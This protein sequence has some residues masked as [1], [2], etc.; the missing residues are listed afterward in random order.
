[1]TKAKNIFSTLTQFRNLDC[2]LS[3]GASSWRLFYSGLRMAALCGQPRPAPGGR[4]WTC[5]LH[6]PGPAAQTIRTNGSAI[7][8]I[9]SARASHYRQPWGKE[10]NGAVGTSWLW[11]TDPACSW[12]NSAGS[13]RCNSQR[14]TLVAWL[15]GGC[16]SDPSS[17]PAL[18]LTDWSFLML[19]SS[20]VVCDSMLH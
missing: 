3:S 2:I 16:V 7:Q 14:G 5:F 19:P 20:S 6:D 4:S 1:M 12:G 8:T 17:G 13:H 15:G 11:R 10:A 9:P 18:Q